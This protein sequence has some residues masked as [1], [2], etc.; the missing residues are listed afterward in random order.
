MTDFIA[1]IYEWFG[2]NTDL[3]QHLRGM[4]IT[5]TDFIGADLY[6]NVFM[7]MLGVSF[8][9]FVVMYLL[10]D[11]VTARFST[12]WSWWIMA[13]IGAAIN[14]GIASSL[15]NTI[16]VCTQ[17]HFGNSDLMLFGLANAVWGLVTFAL[18]TSFPFPRNF[19][20]NSRLTTFW[21]P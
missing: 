16:D 11:R 21:K 14:F 6:F 17:L 4:D 19:S 20:T 13:L 5:C 12:K 10:I 1:S 7:I 2:Y 15:P 18:L 3:G 9:S 8:I